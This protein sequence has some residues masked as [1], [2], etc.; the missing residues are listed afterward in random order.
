MDEKCMSVQHIDRLSICFMDKIVFFPY[1]IWTS[2]PY[3]YGQVFYI[4]HV[5]K[6]MSDYMEK[7]HNESIDMTYL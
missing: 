6:Y 7:V 1:N 2:C 3:M 5:D 4:C